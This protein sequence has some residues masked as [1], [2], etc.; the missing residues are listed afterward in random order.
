[1][2]VLGGC[3]FKLAGTV[4]LSALVK[5][6]YVQA[7]DLNSGQKSILVRQLKQAGAV[8]SV[9]QSAADATLSVSIITLPDR[10]LVAS[11]NSAKTVNR[12][13]RR[14]NYS[15]L[16]PDGSQWINNRQIIEQQDIELDSNNL[17]ASSEVKADVVQNLE[18]TLIER[19]IGQLKRL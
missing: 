7:E 9:E 16:A 17:L 15:F 4:E 11:A 18:R 5:H 12:I 19:M 6:I 1:M 8:V 10:R 3:G 2:V 14:L 13:S